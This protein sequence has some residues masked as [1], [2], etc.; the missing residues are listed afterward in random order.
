MKR[1]TFIL[2]LILEGILAALLAG[3]SEN[4][5]G[6]FP[7]VLSFPLEPIAA[8]LKR[9]AETGAAGNGI[10]AALWIGMGLIPALFAL[11]GPGKR[12]SAAE[13]VALGILSCFLPAALYG[14]M[15]PQVFAPP[16]LGSDPGFSKAVRS[17]FDISVWAALTLYIV[18]R[19]IRL[20]RSG[21]REHLLR[22]LKI[23]LRV[24]C[25]LFTAAV[26]VSLITGLHAA[27]AAQTGADCTVGV[28][29]VLT[30]TVPYF[31][32]ILM[33]LSLLELIGVA[34]SQDPS[35][36]PQAAEKLTRLCCLSLG[37]SAAVPVLMNTVQIL[38][39]PRLTDISVTAQIPAGIRVITIESSMDLYDVMIQESP[40][41]DVIIQAAAVSDYRPAE[42]K[43]RKIKKENGNELSLETIVNFQIRLDLMN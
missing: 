14:M 18:L 30:D 34:P 40:K 16:Q 38:W 19:L 13:R 3:L 17:V 7:T 42:K 10:A 20:L 36:L 21:D 2:L 27:Q 24:L 11:R 26:A 32:D 39:M 8:G 1:K 35:D 33:L 29:R 6:L 37:V 22:Y 25:V 23:L 28:F 15:N 12:M 43:D 5:S 41:H 4:L 9:L 31:M